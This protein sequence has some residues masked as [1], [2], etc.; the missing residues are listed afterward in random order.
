MGFWVWGGKIGTQPI[1]NR[2]N[3][4]SGF[5]YTPEQALLSHFCIL[6]YYKQ[7]CFY[8]FLCIFI[9]SPYKAIEIYMYNHACDCQVYSLTHFLCI[10]PAIWRLSGGLWQP[11]RCNVYNIHNQVHQC[12]PLSIV[13]RIMAFH[14]LLFV[15]LRIIQIIQSIL[16]YYCTNT[17]I[18]LFLY[19]A[20]NLFFIACYP[21]NY[22]YCFYESVI[23]TFYKYPH[24]AR[25]TYQ[26]SYFSI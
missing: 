2:V 25:N 6:V 9:H 5:N 8:R 10:F 19:I 3:E 4:Y 13:M 23:Y 20:Y 22:I 21:I 16:L 26:A 24:P 11:Y 15:L 18:T 7:I 1:W 14:L 12:M 17:T